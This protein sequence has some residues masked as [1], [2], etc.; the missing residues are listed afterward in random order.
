VGLL[1][2]PVYVVLKT[3]AG[4]E[5]EAVSNDT[6]LRWMRI[7]LAGLPT[8]GIALLLFY[9]LGF[10]ELSREKRLYLM[11]A[12][13]LGTIAFPYGVLLFGHQLATL[14][15]V[16]AFAFI[17]RQSRSP[18]TLPPAGCGL[19][20]GCALLVEYTTL[21]L[22]VPL[23]AYAVYASPRRLKDTC[24]GLAGSL[25]PVL[26][27]MGYHTS[28]FGSPLASGYGFLVHGHFAAVHDRGLWGMVTPSFSRLGTILFSP[29][30]GLWF[31]SPWLLLAIPALVMAIARPRLPEW[32]PAWIALAAGSLFYLLFAMSLQLTAWGWSLGPRHLCPLMPFWVLAIGTLLRRSPP[33]PVWT[34]RALRVLV[35][36][37]VVAIALPTATFGGFPPDFN[38]PLAD[39]S[40][41]LLAT[42]CLSPSVG[43][44]VGLSPG[45]AALPFWLAL[46][47]G[48]FWLTWP[49]TGLALEKA[50][51]LGLAAALLGLV[52]FTTGP[53]SPREERALAWAQK[54]I[55]KCTDDGW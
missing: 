20:L 23:A 4:W 55:L 34:M 32:R 13:G 8:A 25:L 26:L 10:L 2:V 18:G 42:G 47:A 41:R 43:T 7:A 15:L 9:L 22:V 36:F 46:A 1:G 49:K 31:Y 38:N 21:L 16:G 30:K 12:Y 6:L 44:A 52:L 29:N 33:W 14:C 37:S 27:L 45:L 40:V 28:C 53:S 19:L 11:L 39:F 51:S 35:P 5:A 50:L 24:L 17:Q 48:I 3:L 54:D